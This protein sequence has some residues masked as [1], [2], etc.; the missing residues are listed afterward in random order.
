MDAPYLLFWLEAPLQ[1]WGYDSR[2]NRRDTLGFPTK[3]GILGMVCCALGAGGKQREFLAQFAPLDLQVHAYVPTDARGNPVPREPLLRD[4]QMVGSGYNDKDPWQTLCIPKT[5]DGKK[6]VGGGTKMTYRYYLQDMA[7][8][9]FFQVP[10][11]LA[12][13]IASAMQQPVW[14]IYL[15]RKCCAPT[16]LIYQGTYAALDQAQVAGKEI[17]LKKHR[18]FS[19]QIVQGEHEGEVLILND[20]PLQFGEYKQYSDRSVTVQYWQE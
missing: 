3:S 20:V 8:A 4:Y 5:A 10:E 19:Y 6:A 14:D 2:F 1:S 16:E 9:V 15:G 13:S 18:S 17:A 11:E 7:F 12:P